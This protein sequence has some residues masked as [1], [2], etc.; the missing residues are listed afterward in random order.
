MLAV[1]LVLQYH[2]YK[3]CNLHIYLLPSEGGGGQNGGNFPQLQNII[4]AKNFSNW[5]IFPVFV[6]DIWLQWRETIFYDC[7]LFFYWFFSAYWSTLGYL[8][9]S[10]SWKFRSFNNLS[11][12][13]IPISPVYTPVVLQNKL[14]YSELKP[15]LIISY[16]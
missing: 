4:E 14:S 10:L 2:H 7:F 3:T 1:L 8:K 12:P 5:N 6:I 11:K 9:R 13:C 15:S 16:L